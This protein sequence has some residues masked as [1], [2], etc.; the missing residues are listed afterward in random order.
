M[1]L[2]IV[3]DARQAGFAVAAQREVESSR[4][5]GTTRAKGVALIRAAVGASSMASSG[6]YAFPV[7][8][9]AINLSNFICVKKTH[10]IFRSSLRDNPRTKG[11]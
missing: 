11:Q 1:T 2:R 7:W 10:C 9:R 6:G 5:V 8:T 4:Y 3:P